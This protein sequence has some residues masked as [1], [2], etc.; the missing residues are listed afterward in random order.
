MSAL[1]TFINLAITGAYL[2]AAL[3]IGPR[4]KGTSDLTRIAG[5]LFFATCGLHHMEGALHL[6]ATPNL[7][8]F[9]MFTTVHMLVIDAVQAASIWLFII[10]VYLDLIIRPQRKDH[11]LHDTDD[12]GS[13]RAG[14]R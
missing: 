3:F 9:E 12:G 11:P 2:F 4:L 6:Q 14:D 10:G 8:V 5:A 1:S 7:T 13:R